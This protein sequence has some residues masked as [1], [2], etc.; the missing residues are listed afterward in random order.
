MSKKL[1]PLPDNILPDDDSLYLSG[2]LFEIAESLGINPSKAT[3]EESNRVWAE[4]ERLRTVWRK[5]LR[6]SQKAASR[7][8]TP[9]S[10]V[11]SANK[12]G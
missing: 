2:E 8:Q 6:Q 10:N 5:K 9:I 1:P 11:V 4:V 7:R 12:R 3:L